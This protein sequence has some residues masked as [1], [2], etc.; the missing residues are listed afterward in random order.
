VICIEDVK[1]EPPVARARDAVLEILVPHH[2]AIFRFAHTS[3]LEA[4]LERGLDRLKMTQPELPRALSR[5]I[6]F[7]RNP[8]AMAIVSERMCPGFDPVLYRQPDCWLEL[9][10]RLPAIRQY[11]RLLGGPSG[12]HRDR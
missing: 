10:G 3:G 6:L 5:C 1:L 2:P 9:A 4:Y 8:R 7:Y 11:A 12:L